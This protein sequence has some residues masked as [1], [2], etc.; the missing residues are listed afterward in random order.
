[1]YVVAAA[2]GTKLIERGAGV[3]YQIAVLLALWVGLT[4]YALLGGA[5]FGGGVWTALA[6]GRA[7]E[8]Q[9]RLIAASIAP[10]WEAN[11]VWLIFVITGLFAA[12]P[13]AFEALSVALYLPFSIALAGIVFRGSA[14]AFRAHGEAGSGWQ[15]TW[16]SIF[17][18]ASIIT[19]F[20]LGASAGAIAAGD[21]RISSTHISADALHVWLQ[22]LPIVTGLLGLSTCAYLAASYLT[23]EART[24]GER[25]MEDAFRTRAI[26]AGVVAGVLAAVGLIAVRAD[27]PVLWRGM[28]H[29]GLPFAGL[30]AAGG[31]VSLVGHLVRRYDVA[32]AGAV[33]AVAALLGGW[34]AAQWPLLIVPDLSVAAAAAPRATL[35]A[36]TIGMIAG[37]ALLAPSLLLLFRVFKSSKSPAGE[38]EV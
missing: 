12:F 27:A 9:R 3:N 21:I 10:V 7:R 1:V 34:G 33:V 31:L 23:I 4:L 22:P 17:G 20:V 38:G 37:G 11:H 35:R 24:R 36:I 32:R 18:V 29:R 8:K 14:F 16:T 5:D 28:L 13:R 6:T 25:D 26:V 30:S 2:A 15:R 19:P